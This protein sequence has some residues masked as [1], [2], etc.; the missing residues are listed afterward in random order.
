[1]LRAVERWR[2]KIETF[3]AKKG[4]HPAKSFKQ[5]VFPGELIASWEMI[6]LLESPQITVD[7]RLDSRRRPNKLNLVI[8]E[9]LAI[10]EVVVAVL[11]G[12][13]FW[14]ALFKAIAFQDVLHKFIFVICKFEHQLLPHLW[15]F[16]STFQEGDTRALL[17]CFVVKVCHAE[18]DAVLPLL[19]LKF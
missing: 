17:K 12:N 1:M 8:L 16:A 6:N 2:H 9:E 4:L 3:I 11:N 10:L 18:S 15:Q 7:V 19:P 14:L 5:E 13:Q